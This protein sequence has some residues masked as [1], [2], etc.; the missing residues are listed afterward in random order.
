MRGNR[1]KKVSTYE[2]ISEF[3]LDFRYYDACVNINAYN[4]INADSWR[5]YRQSFVILN[6]SYNGLNSKISGYKADKLHIGID[7][8]SD[9]MIDGVDFA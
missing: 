6:I 9:V 2:G 3:A 7:D 4:I 8:Y 1:H 5:K